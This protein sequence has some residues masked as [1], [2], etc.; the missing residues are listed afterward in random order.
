MAQRMTL[1][2]RLVPASL[3]NDN[4]AVRRHQACIH[5]LGND[6]RIVGERHELKDLCLLRDSHA[7]S[8]P[9]TQH[10]MERLIS[11]LAGR[12][13]RRLFEEADKLSIYFAANYQVTRYCEISRRVVNVPPF[14]TDPAEHSSFNRFSNICYHASTGECH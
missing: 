9:I 12:A 3:A 2:S 10:G 8:P 5:D 14:P 13:R 6:E 11:A 1:N 4:E 7:L